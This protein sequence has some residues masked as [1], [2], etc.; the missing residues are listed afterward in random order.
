MLGFLTT[1]SISVP[2]IC[3]F[4]HFIFSWLSLGRL[5]LLRICLFLQ[6]CVVI[7]Y[8][9]MYFCGIGCNC[10]SFISKFIDFSPLHFFFLMNLAKGLSILCIFLKNNFFSFT[11]VCYWFFFVSIFISFCFTLYNFISSTNFRFCL[12]FFLQLFYM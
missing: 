4:I 8:D 11:D 2:L 1:V 6:G 5:Y 7:S 10:S 3:L 12:F 9:P